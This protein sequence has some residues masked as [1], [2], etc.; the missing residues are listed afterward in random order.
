MLTNIMVANFL[1][2]LCKIIARY[3]SRTTTQTVRPEV[4]NFASELLL[5]RQLCEVTM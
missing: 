5:A 1:F 3:Q 2:Y 4:R